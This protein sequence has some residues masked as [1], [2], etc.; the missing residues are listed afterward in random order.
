[1]QMETQFPWGTGAEHIV[2][3]GLHFPKS[4]V[5]EI[6]GTILKHLAHNILPPT[7]AGEDAHAMLAARYGVPLVSVRAALYDIAWD[8]DALRSLT[9]WSRFMLLRDDIHPTWYGHHLYGR[10]LVA[11]ALRQLLSRE[12]GALAIG[13]GAGSAGIPPPLPM[14]VT[15]GAAR[16]ADGEPFCAEGAALQAHVR[17]AAAQ[18]AGWAWTD[19][20]NASQQDWCSSPNCHKLGYTA[21]GGGT[22]LDI[23]LDSTAATGGP[24]LDARELVVFYAKSPQPGEM[25]TA[26]VECLSGCSCKPFTLNGLNDDESSQLGYERARV[27][28]RVQSTAQHMRRC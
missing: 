1:M 20:A 12:L 27:R 23:T 15:P 10:G 8:D 9:G 25:G 28:V 21:R 14:P 17:R 19:D 18:A 3:V 7:R 24:A 13:A 22:A 2:V 11:W 6:L 26:V 4:I 5:E 16:E